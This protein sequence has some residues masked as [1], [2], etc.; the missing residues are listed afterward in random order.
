MLPLLALRRTKEFDKTKKTN[1]QT[2]KKKTE[3]SRI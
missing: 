1:K 2:N 3:N